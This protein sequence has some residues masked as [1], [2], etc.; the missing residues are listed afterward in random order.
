MNEGVSGEGCVLE[1]RMG[2]GTVNPSCS[3]RG[4][5]KGWRMPNVSP[6][7][8]PLGMVIIH[9]PAIREWDDGIS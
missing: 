6:N 8:R 7:K 3:I 5:G 2:N 9:W 1:W 4:S